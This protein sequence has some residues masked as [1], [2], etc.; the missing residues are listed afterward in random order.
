MANA[1]GSSKEFEENKA[2]IKMEYYPESALQL[3]S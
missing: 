3:A 2:G 1:F